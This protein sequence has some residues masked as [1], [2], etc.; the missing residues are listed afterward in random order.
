MFPDK[1]IVENENR[2]FVK[3]IVQKTLMN[4]ILFVQ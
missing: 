2:Y 1:C 4:N 3:Q